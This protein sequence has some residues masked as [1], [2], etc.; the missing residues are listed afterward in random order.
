MARIVIDTDAVRLLARYTNGAIDEVA[1]IRTE[2][3]KAQAILD[4]GPGADAFGPLLGALTN[5]ATVLTDDYRN[6][7]AEVTTI[8]AEEGPAAPDWTAAAD[9]DPGVSMLELIAY[10]VT[11]LS[12]GQAPALPPP[13]PWNTTWVTSGGVIPLGFPTRS[14]TAGQAAADEAGFGAT[15]ETKSETDSA[16]G[17]NSSSASVKVSVSAGQGASESTDAQGNTTYSWETYQE[18]VARAHAETSGDLGGV[19]YRFEGTA[20]AGASADIHVWAKGGPDGYGAGGEASARV[21]T[22]ATASGEI[23]A[24]EIGGAQGYVTGSAGAGAS[25]GAH[26]QV[27]THGGEGGVSVDAYDGADAKLGGGGQLGPLKGSREISVGTGVGVGF[28]SDIS[29]DWDDIGFDFGGELG[30][31]ISLGIDTSVHLSPSGIVHGL[32]SLLHGDNPFDSS[33]EHWQHQ[34]EDAARHEA[35]RAAEHAQHDLLNQGASVGDTSTDGSPANSDWI[36]TFPKE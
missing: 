13:E 19:D 35:E 24:R 7:V 5:Y 15:W 32:G 18:M 17:H 14:T 4:Q 9:S 11:S 29:L 27:S 20:E 16:S 22:D 3:L 26:G 25:A 21:Y 36:G 6:L 1:H 2:L 33:G 31:G 12:V 30:L 28:S 10:P 34:A 23:G 8:E